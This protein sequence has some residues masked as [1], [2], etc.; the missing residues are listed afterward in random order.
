MAKNLLAFVLDE[1]LQLSVSQQF[2]V[3]LPNTVAGSVGKFVIP[4]LFRSP[5]LR[6]D[7]SEQVFAHPLK[8]PA[9]AA[10]EYVNFFSF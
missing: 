2:T 6:N 8:N 10:S 5:G 1:K 3:P 7:L 9:F 4:K